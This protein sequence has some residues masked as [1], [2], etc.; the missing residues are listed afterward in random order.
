LARSLLSFKRPLSPV[1]VSVRL[2]RW[3]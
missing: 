1:D 3:C 2:Q